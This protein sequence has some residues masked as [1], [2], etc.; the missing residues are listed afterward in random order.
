[1]ESK[2][3]VVCNAEKSIENFTTNI[4][5]VKSVIFNEV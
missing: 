5:N 2:V 1:M 3:F 4:E